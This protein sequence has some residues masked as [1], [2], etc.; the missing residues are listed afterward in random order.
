[1]RRSRNIARSKKTKELGDRAKDNAN[2]HSKK[3]SVNA[4]KKTQTFQ[5]TEEARRVLLCQRL[6]HGCLA[7]SLGGVVGRLCAGAGTPRKHVT[8]V[9]QILTLTPL[10]LNPQTYNLHAHLSLDCDRLRCRQARRV[11]LVQSF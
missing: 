11:H 6:S 9:P 2:Q 10:T 7:R 4:W 8:A 5:I 3:V 1:M